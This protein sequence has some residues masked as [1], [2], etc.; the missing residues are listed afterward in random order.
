MGRCKM[1]NPKKQS[2]FICL[3]C[4]KRNHIGDGIQRGGRQRPNGHE[5]NLYCLHCKEVTLNLEIRY[6]DNYFEKIEEAE[7]KHIKYYGKVKNFI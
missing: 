1:G 2:R 3:Q 4:L 7:K 5:K 6:C